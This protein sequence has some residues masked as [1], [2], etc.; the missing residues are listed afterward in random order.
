LILSATK[1]GAAVF[2][3][4]G[5]YDDSWCAPHVSF[6]VGANSDLTVCELTVWLRSSEERTTSLFSVRF[7]DREPFEFDVP[8]EHLVC[9]QAACPCA[10][11]GHDK[12]RNSMCE[13][14]PD[15]DRRCQTPVVYAPKREVLVNEIAQ[16]GKVSREDAVGRMIDVRG[17]DLVGELSGAASDR[18]V[19]VYVENELIG[20]A[21]L[22]NTASDDG[23][24][25]TRFTF[26]L[27]RFLYDGRVHQLKFYLNGK[28]K[29]LL[30]GGVFMFVG[31]P[32]L[33]EGKRAAVGQR[34][35]AA[36]TPAIEAPTAT[37]AIE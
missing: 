18:Q 10:P 22:A 8:H 17:R 1:V 9:V 34:P 35:K 4:V 19:V 12:S 23:S 16:I 13:F 2:N 32:A 25:N 20:S 36:P 5:V 28:P 29:S 21:Q 33:A 37:P 11:G 27:P 30:K 6:G 15:H 31:D 7:N 3:V 26:R 14:S 24:E